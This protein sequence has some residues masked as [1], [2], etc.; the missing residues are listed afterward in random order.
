MKLNDLICSP[1][2]DPYSDEVKKLEEKVEQE[3]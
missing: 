3:H 2:Y 1:N